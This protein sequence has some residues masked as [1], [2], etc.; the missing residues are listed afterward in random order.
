MFLYVIGEKDGHR[1]WLS[2]GSN[3][4]E[5]LLNHAA[6]RHGE[7]NAYDRADD[8]LVHTGLGTEEEAMKILIMR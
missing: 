4:E 5:A 7:S 1:Q 8:Y 6:R 2:L 3:E